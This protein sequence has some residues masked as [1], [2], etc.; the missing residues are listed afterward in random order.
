MADGHTSMQGHK[1]NDG[2]GAGAAKRGDSQKKDQRRK[3]GKNVIVV[4]AGVLGAVAS[5]VT[6]LAYLQSR[7]SG[8]P[9]FDADL[10]S[11]AAQFAN[12][13]SGSDGKVVYIHIQCGEADVNGNWKTSSNNSQSSKCISLAEDNSGTNY[14]FILSLGTFSAPQYYYGTANTSRDPQTAWINVVATPNT[15]AE[16]YNGPRGAGWLE[17]KGYFQVT[18]LQF[19]DAPPESQDYELRAVSQSI[20]TQ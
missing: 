3:L 8:P 2:E 1:T 12:F 20:G 5:L 17:I 11:S 10:T 18:S 6:I 14:R 19:G 16:A 13:L 4:A 9:S 15:G 7:P